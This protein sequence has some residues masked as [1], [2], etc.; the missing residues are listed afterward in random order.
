MP[1]TVFFL[2]RVLRETD[3]LK[4]TIRDLPSAH[5]EEVSIGL[6]MDFSVKIENSKVAVECQVNR[7]Q[8]TDLP[9]L[10]VR[11]FDL[12]RAAVDILAFSRGWGL[13]VWIDS[14]TDPSGVET[15]LLCQMPQLAALCTA[16]DLTPGTGNTD[17]VW[18][19]VVSE[20]ALFMALNDLIASIAL[21]HHA[22]VNCARAIDGILRMMIP[23]GSDPKKS[24]PFMHQNLN[25][26]RKYLE[27]ITDQSTGPRHGDRSHIPGPDVNITVERSWNV[28]NRFLEFRKRGNQPL[29]LAVFP[30]LAG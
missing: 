5:W 11:A 22:P 27:Y 4:I 6:V 23:A 17:D 29:P 21:P 13:T 25:V 1:Q 8:P 3:A 12:A 20:P 19:L 9:Y 18:R 16:F 24:W 10:H 14:F 15:P 30:L 7:Y 28:M 26:D 2:G